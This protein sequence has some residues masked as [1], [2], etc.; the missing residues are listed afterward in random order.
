MIALLSLLHTQKL[1]IRGQ[2]AS[3]SS[4]V[5]R[6]SLF[7]RNIAW[8]VSMIFGDNFI[9]VNS[10]G[11]TVETTLMRL[12]LLRDPSREIETRR[13][14][15]IDREVE[16]EVGRKVKDFEENDD[17][18]G[19]LDA[20]E[21]VGLFHS[22]SLSLFFFEIRDMTSS[23]YSAFGVRSRSI[24]SRLLPYQSISFWVFSK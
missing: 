16:R 9:I 15:E 3:N 24:F 5:Q 12:I 11:V 20:S 14:W 18:D 7:N 17:D 8:R 2:Y 1:S 6:M 10:S 22:P 4:V 23:R 21:Y 19:D 13:L